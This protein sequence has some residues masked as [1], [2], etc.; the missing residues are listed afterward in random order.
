MTSIQSCHAVE[1][2]ILSHTLHTPAI[3]TEYTKVACSRIHQTFCTLHIPATTTNIHKL[4]GSRIC[5]TLWHST[6]TCDHIVTRLQLSN[7]LHTPATTTNIHRL[8]GSRTCKILWH[9]TRTCNHIVVKYLS[10]LTP[11]RWVGCENIRVIPCGRTYQTFWHLYIWLSFYTCHTPATTTWRDCNFLTP[12]T[13]PQ[14]LRIYIRC[15]AVEYIRL[16]DTL[17]TPAI[18]TNIRRMLCS[19]IHQTFWHVTHVGWLRLVGSIK[20]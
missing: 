18:T 8:P 2:I 19:G 13:H 11:R 20:L 7:T 1:Y 10:S 3:N 5:K 12:Y 16:S 4:P 6:R 9:F 14:L 15:H 17:H